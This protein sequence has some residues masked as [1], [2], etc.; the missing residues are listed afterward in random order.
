MDDLEQSASAHTRYTRSTADW[1]RIMV[2]LIGYA[3]EIPVYQ[4]DRLLLYSAAGVPEALARDLDA[5]AFDEALSVYYK[6]TMKQ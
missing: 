1:L 2:D 5:R 6:A 4:K 3:K